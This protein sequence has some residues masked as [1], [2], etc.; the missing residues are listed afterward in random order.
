MVL[1]YDLL[2]DGHKDS[3]TMN[4]FFLFLSNNTNGLHV[5][6]GLYSNRS[7]GTSKCGGTF[8]VL[9]TFSHHLGSFT[10]QK[11]GIMGSTC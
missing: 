4:D 7:H 10:E 5:A 1:T 2:E 11:H 8:L 9:T 3:F 6:V